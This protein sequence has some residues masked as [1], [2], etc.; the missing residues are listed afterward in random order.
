LHADEDK[1]KRELIETRNIADNMVYMTEKTLREAGDKVSADVKKEIEEK[2]EALK[3]VK[4]GDNI[5]DIKN[6]TNDLSQIIQ[7]V[8]AEMY[9]A[10]QE[11]KPGG[12]EPKA[13]EGE[14][15]EKS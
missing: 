3:K 5:D 4:D 6:K 10:A 15:H 2:A 9:K 14:Y 12:E 1:K 13:E 8:G 11:Q 7:K